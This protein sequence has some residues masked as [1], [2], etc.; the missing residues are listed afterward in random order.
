[1]R[2]R[3]EQGELSDS[4]VICCWV[5]SDYGD[6]SFETLV[7][8]MKKEKGEELV[9]LTEELTKLEMVE[10]MSKEAF[11]KQVE[12]Y[13]LA[14][15]ENISM[16]QAS[17]LFVKL[18]EARDKGIEGEEVYDKIIASMRTPNYST[19]DEKPQK[20]KGQ[21]EKLKEPDLDD[22]VW[23]QGSGNV[24]AEVANKE[25]VTDKYEVAYD[26]EGNLKTLKKKEV[27]KT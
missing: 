23:V 16:P 7:E 8:K 19:T 13:M 27:K 3:F 25:F 20:E 14:T 15:Q 9:K 10:N 22:I 6:E 26:S 1:M 11:Y 2:R 5:A 24:K 21:V 17:R 18:E 12:I 4:E